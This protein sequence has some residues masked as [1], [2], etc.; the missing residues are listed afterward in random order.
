MAI[1]GTSIL[2]NPL[3]NENTKI[4]EAIMQRFMPVFVEAEYLYK[5][6]KSEKNIIW[7][8]RVKAYGDHILDSIE[9]FSEGIELYPNSY[10]LYRHRGHRYL[11]IHRIKDALADFTKSAQL[12]E[13]YGDQ[14][15][16]EEDGVAN[17]LPIPPE[18]TG[19]NIYY[20]LAVSAYLCNQLEVAKSANDKVFD[21]CI[22]DEDIVAASDWA[23]LIRRRMGDKIG[24]EAVI[25]NVSN[26]LSIV[27]NIGYYKR[28][29]F[30][31][32][33]L[34]YEDMLKIDTD[35]EDFYHKSMAKISQLYGVAAYYIAEGNITKAKDILED[36][37]H[38]NKQFSAF[39]HIASECDLLMIQEG[40]FE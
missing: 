19:F 9:L 27:D 37:L 4:S 6:E 36:C 11:S 33:L 20:H 15:E 7:W 24:A 5:M 28:I 26:D 8:G 31:K 22:N 40:Q 3:D 13:K 32:G 12:F 35:S 1:I 30:Y 23:Y 34:S 25:A 21:Y 14:N 18:K 29:K 16:M 17:R 10:R 39:A 2:G 38:D